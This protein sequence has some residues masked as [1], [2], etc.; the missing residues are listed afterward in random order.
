MRWQKFEIRNGEAELKSN[1]NRPDVECDI[2][3]SGCGARIGYNERGMKGEDE[4]EEVSVLFLGNSDKPKT[5]I[6]EDVPDATP[7]TQ[8]ET[9]V[10]CDRYT[11]YYQNPN[12]NT[13]PPSVDLF[14][15]FLAIGASDQAI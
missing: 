1:G 3:V 13:Y 10:S 5:T 4:L 8:G 11:N 6:L 9:C 2:T 15:L 12:Y 14:L 7:K